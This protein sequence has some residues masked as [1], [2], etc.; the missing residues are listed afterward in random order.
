MEFAQALEAVVKSF[1]RKPS[2]LQRFYAGLLRESGQDAELWIESHKA[3]LAAAAKADREARALF[4]E[5]FG[6]GKYR[7][8]PSGA[9]S[10][11]GQAPN[12][13]ETCWWLYANSV[14]RAVESLT[15]Y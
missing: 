13:F 8:E 7:I 2:H 4:R 15:S 14:E 10:V 12:S 3:R 5:N 6:T 9:V 11:Y 1:P